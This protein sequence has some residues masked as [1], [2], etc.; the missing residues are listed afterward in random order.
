MKKTKQLYKV[1][2]CR[3]NFLEPN[4]FT[5]VL[6]NVSSHVHKLIKCSSFEVYIYLHN[7]HK[8][9]IFKTH[10]CII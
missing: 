1:Y 2:S 9:F 3:I 4:T 7:M 5:P 10:T 6:T 8:S